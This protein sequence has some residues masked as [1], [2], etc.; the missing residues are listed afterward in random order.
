MKRRRLEKTDSKRRLALGGENGQRVDNKGKGREGQQQKQNAEARNW[1]V[2][3]ER[4]AKPFSVVGKQV[5][6]A[7]DMREGE[8]GGVYG[9]L[10]GGACG[11]TSGAVE[12]IGA[13]Q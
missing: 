8:G 11:C 5:G 13:A 3:K 2:G 12:V 10:G 4:N 7:A 1:V 6:G 9:Q